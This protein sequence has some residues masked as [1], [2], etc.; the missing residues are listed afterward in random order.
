MKR[1]QRSQEGYLCV[2]N[3]HAPPIPDDLVAIARAAGKNPIGA[4]VQGVLEMP[5]VRC[6]HCHTVRLVQPLRTRT[7][8][9]C[10]G[11]CETLCDGCAGVAHMTGECRS[12]DAR[13]DMA[14][15][16]MATGKTKALSV[17]RETVA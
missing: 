4:K 9:V 2:E 12:L 17:L 1:T 6:G 8:P 7:R 13:F 16:A 15:E 3:E 14:Q 10:R 5:A 11:C